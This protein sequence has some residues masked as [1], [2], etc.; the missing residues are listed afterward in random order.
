MV[1]FVKPIDKLTVRTIELLA[2]FFPQTLKRLFQI[3]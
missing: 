1:A 3:F 2:E